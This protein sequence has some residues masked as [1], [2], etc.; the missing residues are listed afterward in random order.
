MEHSKSN[1][2]S[3]HVE[4]RHEMLVEESKEELCRVTFM[5]QEE[6][7]S[8]SEETRK[9]IDDEST[10]MRNEYFDESKVARKE[11]EYETED[12]LCRMFD[13]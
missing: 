3:T 6:E 8:N 2:K 10:C 1:K 4:A 7:F 11:L 13:G 5:H 12:L 9:D